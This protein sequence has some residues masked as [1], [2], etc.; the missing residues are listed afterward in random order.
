MPY[1]HFEIDRILARDEL[2]T[3]RVLISCSH[4]SNMSHWLS[5]ARTNNIFIFLH[6]YVCIGLCLYTIW[7]FESA[8]LIVIVVFST[9]I[10]WSNISLHAV[11]SEYRKGRGLYC[12]MLMYVILCIILYYVIYPILSCPVMSGHVMSCHI[13]Y[14]ISYNILY[15]S[16]I[17]HRITWQWYWNNYMTQSKFASTLHVLFR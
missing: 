3:S 16:N 11:F 13:S 15:H 7:L 2:L 1:Y 10:S 17:S 8:T 14:H 5:V 6:M 12:I 9:H 4:C